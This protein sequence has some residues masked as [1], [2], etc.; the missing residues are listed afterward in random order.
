MFAIRLPREIEERLEA[1][2]KR[3]GRT[4]TFYVREAILRHLEDLEDICIAEARLENI[5]VGRSK[6]IPIEDQDL[7]PR[8]D[9]PV[10][11]YGSTSRSASDR[12]VAK[13]FPARALDYGAWRSRG[14]QRPSEWLRFSSPSA[15]SSEWS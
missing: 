14:S 13:S 12:N 9:F 1:L 3:T 11:G 6:T 5:R 2:A 4:K 7:W 10:S 15:S 8:L